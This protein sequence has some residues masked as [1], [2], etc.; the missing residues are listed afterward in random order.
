MDIGLSGPL[1]GIET[2][3]RIRR[4]FSIL[5]IFVTAYTSEETIKRTEEVSPDGYIG[6]PFLDEVILA[7]IRK[8]IDSRSA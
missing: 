8:V 2:A 6:K 5:L 1:D 4:R 7:L 3:R